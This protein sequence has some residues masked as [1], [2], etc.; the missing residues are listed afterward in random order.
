MP[1]AGAPVEF[2]VLGPLE[3][4]VDAASVSIT[5]RRQRAVLA[6]LLLRGGEVLSRDELIE[7]LWENDPPA[8]AS[9]LLRLYVSQVRRRL[10]PGRLVTRGAG[11]ALT[12]DPGQLDAERF[13]GLFADA[14]RAR[15]GGNPRLARSLCLRALALWRG[16]ALADLPAES[17]AREAA[18]RLEELRL[19]CTEERVEAELDL[20]RHRDV[21][22]EL[23]LLVAQN[24]RRDL[25]RRQLMLALYRAGRQA[26]ALASY[27]TAREALVEE[28][29][30]EPGRELRELEQLILLQDPSLELDPV[31]ERPA[32]HRRVIAP[33]TP[34]IGRDENV[35]EVCRLLSTSARLVTLVGPGGVGKTRLAVESAA[36][37]GEQLVDG[38][39]LVE[40]AALRD[41]DLLLASIGHALGL[42]ETGGSS[43]SELLG[44]HL[45]PL[46]LLLVLDNLE[47]L[48]EGCAPLVELLAVAPRVRVLATSTTVLR[49]SA[50]HV[51]RVPPLEPAP[52]F[53][54][55]LR[56]T[57][58]AGAPA[59]SV[60]ASREA[61]AQV[62]DRLAGS[63]LAIELTAPW[64]RTISPAELLALVD[65]RLATLRNELRDA[66]ARHRTL[67]STI[68]WSF[69]LLATEEQRLFVELSVFAGGF[70]L[71]AA[72]AVA[73]SDETIER[74][75]SLVAA[76]LVHM[77]GERYQLLN[78]VREYAAERLDGDFEP[79]RRHAEHFAGLVEAAEE[80]LSG[81][82]QGD[83]L[84]LLDVEHDNLR[85]VLDW[86][87]ARDDA[88]AAEL[89]LA[90][91]LGR[92]WY[93]RGHIR[94]GLT[95]LTHAIERGADS[96]AAA[97]AKALRGGS[98]LAV[99]QGDYALAH[100]FAS[101]SL[102]IYRELG[103]RVGAA[104]SL[105]NLGAILHAQGELDLAAVTLDECIRECADLHEDRLLAL[106]QNNRGDVALSQ[107]DLDTAAARFEQSLTILRTLGDTA[108]VARSLYNLGAVAVE[109]DRV[110]AARVLLGES[111]VLSEGVGDTEDVAWCLIALAAVASRTGQPRDGARM[112][113]FAT[114]LLE[115]I[116]ADMK[117]FEQSLFERT[118]HALEGAL[119][120]EE[121]GAALA[122]GAHLDLASAVG[123]AASPQPADPRAGIASIALLVAPLP[124]P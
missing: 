109:Q 24:P 119:G 111:I 54:L 34:T 80:Q 82:G 18:D 118:H 116:G 115:R 25:L 68:D 40:L 89:R 41:P 102:S 88:A 74:L 5:P 67:R 49:L 22:A 45:R 101:R 31:G 85:A 55:F 79:H 52:A 7:A 6:A 76:S 103:D 121:L 15:V 124:H 117:P 93:V 14:R 59:A 87:G 72:Q 84:A 30:L 29:G 64:L 73:R 37:I 47:H 20:G 38:A 65:S 75:E 86:L 53:E 33:P 10:P 17:F 4:I 95:R 98:A 60:A 90:A 35:A 66:P 108:N 61:L 83:A 114:T 23:E 112:L 110:D 105:S 51:L 19:Q 99:I 28:L 107:A 104:R 56:Q 57:I 70:S 27:R 44:Q 69:D 26:D 42:L 97:L 50:E 120:A 8:S 106:A 100:D 81:S 58:A 62:C 43:W 11:Y 78:V 9:S 2:R 71:E 91:G 46:E 39:V 94:E 13:E 122:Q 77:A 113:G 48:L 12:L 63:P 36:L 21:L 32:E 123:L 1:T 16:S 92:F 3:V 96:D